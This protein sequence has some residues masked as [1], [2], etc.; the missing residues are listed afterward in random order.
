V[1]ILSDKARELFEGPNFAAVA[2]MMPDGS[3]QVSVVWIETEGDLI[4]FGTA[5]KR[6][7]E[8]NLRRDPRVAVTVWDAKNP[9]RQ[10]MVRGRVTEITREGADEAIDRLSMKYIGQPFPYRQPGETRI[11]VKIRPEHVTEIG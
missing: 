7:K 11:T 1:T 2:T 9:Y 5:E 3:P 6:T 8:R 4:V 10:V